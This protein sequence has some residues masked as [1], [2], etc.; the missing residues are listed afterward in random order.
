[1]LARQAYYIAE[2]LKNQWKKPEELKKLQK[3][4]LKK[5]IKYAYEKTE[6]YH[7]KFRELDVTP[8]DFTTLEDLQKFPCV[9]KAEMRDAFP[10]SVVSRDYDISKCL[11]GTTSGSTGEV[12]P[13]V[14][15]HATHEYQ[16]AVTYRNFAALG[17]K[18]WHRF[19]YMRYEPIYEGTRFYERVGIAKKRFISVFLEPEEQVR[20]I[21]EFNP[22]AITGYP[23]IMVEWAKTLTDKDAIHPLF[24][25]SEAEILTKEAQNFIENQFGCN[26]YEEYG[27]IEFI[28]IAFECAERGFHMTGD[29]LFLEFLEDGEPVAPG[30][31]GDVYATSLVS[32][33]MP[34]IRYNLNDRGVPSDDMCSCGRGLPLMKLVEGRDDDFL[35]L[36]SGKRMSPRIIIPIFELTDVVKEFRIIQKR[37]DFIEVDIVPSSAFTEEKGKELKEFFLKVLGEPV[38]VG[39]NLCEEIPRGRHNRPRPIRSLVS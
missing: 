1:M 13:V 16:M 19:A 21:K 17:F 3:K 26:V 27:S 7:R 22:H 38:E 6:L 35:C 20:I 9:T 31:E 36:P 23:S 14:Y 10:E 37:R 12:L 30:E 32:Y 4:R 8:S 29:S 18:P 15:S 5:V 34:F 2:V 25:R 39:F 24:I 28:L 33:A 11:K